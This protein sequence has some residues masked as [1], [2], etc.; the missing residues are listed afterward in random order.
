MNQLPEDPDPAQWVQG[1]ES[2]ELDED[3]ARIGKEIMDDTLL[4]AYIDSLTPGSF[5]VEAK[6]LMFSEVKQYC[7]D[8]MSLTRINQRNDRDAEKVLKTHVRDAVAYLRSQD[9]QPLDIISD[10]CK[11]IGFTFFGFAVLQF[12]R[13]QSEKPIL[14]GSVNW[15][16]ID[17]LICVV[18]I[19]AGFIIDRPWSDVIKKLRRH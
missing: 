7:D 15:L 12:L 1:E 9:E 11:W 17:V 4:T 6:A 8:L 3:E 18:L 5:T 2:V 14:H 13:V 16:V 19:A 10:W